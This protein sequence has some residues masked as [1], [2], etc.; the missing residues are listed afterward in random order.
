MQA[1]NHY[2]LADIKNLIVHLHF[3]IPKIGIFRIR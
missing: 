3:H 2:L 1:K